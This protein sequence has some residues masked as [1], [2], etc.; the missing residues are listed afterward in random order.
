MN[1]SLVIGP[2]VFL[3]VLAAILGAF[4]RAKSKPGGSNFVALPNRG[5][6][7]LGR[8]GVPEFKSTWKDAR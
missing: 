2:I 7:D 4:P 1:W 3:V 5:S 6:G 8:S